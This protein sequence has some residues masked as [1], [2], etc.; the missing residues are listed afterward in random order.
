[1]NKKQIKNLLDKTLDFICYKKLE[2]DFYLTLPKTERKDI[3]AYLEGGEY[4][5]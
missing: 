4:E 2:E 1:M 3:L 5:R